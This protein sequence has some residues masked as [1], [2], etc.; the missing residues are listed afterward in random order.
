MSLAI[1]ILDEEYTPGQW[2]LGLLMT[3]PGMHLTLH[4]GCTV[5]VGGGSEVGA[6]RTMLAAAKRAKNLT[7]KERFIVMWS[8]GDVLQS[9]RWSVS[10]T[11]ARL[12]RFALR[13]TRAVLL[14]I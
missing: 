9:G 3:T 4:T 1:A 6:A 8:I 10:A 14:S 2:Q 11:S 13:M 12:Y 7:L 5:V